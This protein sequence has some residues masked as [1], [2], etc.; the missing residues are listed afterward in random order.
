MAPKLK[1]APPAT[2]AH[3]KILAPY[4][5]GK[6]IEEVKRQFG[7]DSVIKLASNENP[8]GPSPRAL[9]ALAAAAAEMNLYPDGL[10]FY[11]KTALAA[12]LGVAPD[13]LVLGAGSDEIVTFLALAY[14]NPRRE[15]ITSNYSFVRYVMAAQLAGARATLIPMK[16]MKHDLNAIAG[17]HRQTDGDGLPRHPLQSDRHDRDPARADPFP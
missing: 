10:G 3:V 13:E 5:P 12:R 14:L 16:D 15:L 4:P 11:L 6:P 17:R 7:L 8:L 1:A 2:N 9:K